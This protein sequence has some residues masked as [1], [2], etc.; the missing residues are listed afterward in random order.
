MK[1]V[2]SILAIVALFAAPSAVA[3]EHSCHVQKGECGSVKCSKQMCSADDCDTV[4]KKH[5]RMKAK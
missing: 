5:C 2:L 3:S 4:C 1:K